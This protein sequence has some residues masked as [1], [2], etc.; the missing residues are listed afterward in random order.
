MRRAAIAVLLAGMALLGT[1]PA[2]L[3]QERTTREEC[4]RGGGR[5]VLGPGVEHYCIGGEH[6]GE[7][8]EG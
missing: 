5:V 3:A 6:H 4:E 7:V 1:A 8:V 2:A